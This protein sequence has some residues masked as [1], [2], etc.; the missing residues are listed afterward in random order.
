MAKNTKK[1]PTQ[2]EDIDNIIRYLKN[3]ND[4]NNYEQYLRPII[5]QK[6]QQYVD[7]LLGS[8]I[9][10]LKEN[11]LSLNNIEFDENGKMTVVK[12]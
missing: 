1:I 8:T 6:G 10:V 3:P 4:S 12:E 9:L 11:E 2:S 7:K 5:K